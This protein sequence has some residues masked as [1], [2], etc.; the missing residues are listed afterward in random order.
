M[1][2]LVVLSLPKYSFSF[3]YEHFNEGLRKKKKQPE[4]YFLSYVQEAGFS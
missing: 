3:F 1:C 4:C 2:P